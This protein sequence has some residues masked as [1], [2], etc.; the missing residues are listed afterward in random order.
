MQRRYD[1]VITTSLY[2]NNITTLY[3]RLLIDVFFATLLQRRDMVERRRDVKTIT[4]QCHY[5]VVSLLGIYKKFIKLFY[6]T[7]KDLLAQFSLDRMFK[8]QQAREI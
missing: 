1:V 4:L 7:P 3:R 2:S 6:T 5:D 8:V